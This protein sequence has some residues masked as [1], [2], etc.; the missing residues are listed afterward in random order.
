MTAAS[1][2]AP[3]LLTIHLNRGYRIAAPLLVGIGSLALFGRSAMLSWRDGDLAG[4]ITDVLIL[5]VL[6]AVLLV[7]RELR[8]EVTETEIGGYFAIRPL[9]RWVPRKEIVRLEVKRLGP[10]RQW[11][12]LR[13][14][15]SIAIGTNELLWNARDLEALSVI[16]GVSVARHS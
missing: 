12:L 9:G 2:D 16:L 10:S 3:S 5:L 6:L 14:D 8:M 15:G 11:L 7:A 13:A 4:T 1:P